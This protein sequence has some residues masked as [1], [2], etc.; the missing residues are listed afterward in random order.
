VVIRGLAAMPSSEMGLL[1]GKSMARIDGQHCGSGDVE[2]EDA[3][4]PCA[5]L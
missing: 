4:D 5:Y 3:T 1:Q 2:L